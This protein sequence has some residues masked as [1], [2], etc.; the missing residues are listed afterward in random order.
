MKKLL[1]AIGATLIVATPAFATTAKKKHPHH[2]QKLYMQ[3]PAQQA[4]P[5][6]AMM[7]RGKPNTSPDPFIN[8][9]LKRSYMGTGQG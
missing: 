3:A 6:P 8:N 9:Y 5:E 2:A 4:Q 1:V 7:N